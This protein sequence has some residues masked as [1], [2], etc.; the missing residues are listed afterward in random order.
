MAKRF[1]PLLYAWCTSHSIFFLKGWER[2]FW[3][4]LHFLQL[5]I[6]LFCLFLRNFR[7]LPLCTPRLFAFQL[8]SFLC[9]VHKSYLDPFCL[10]CLLKASFLF[11]LSCLLAFLLEVS[12][13]CLLSCSLVLL[14]LSFALLLSYC[15]VLLL[16]CAHVLALACFIA[17]LLASVSIFFFFGYWL[18]CSLDL[19]KF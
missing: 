11:F 19:Y 2:C 18:Q 12:S 1:L 5:F 15:V 8:A 3:Q 17:S 10:L 9:F 7:A 14:S 4:P 6:L 16:S 13:L